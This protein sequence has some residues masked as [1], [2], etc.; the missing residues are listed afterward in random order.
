MPDQVLKRLLS[1]DL[2]FTHLGGA[3]ELV[4]I[5]ID[6]EAVAAQPG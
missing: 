2:R 1:E 6:K 4:L 5:E 3:L